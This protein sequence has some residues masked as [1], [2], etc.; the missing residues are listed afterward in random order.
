MQHLESTAGS[1]IVGD[2][3]EWLDRRLGALAVDLERLLQ[4]DRALAIAVD[5]LTKRVG[6]HSGDE[7]D[8]RQLVAEHLLL[9]WV[10]A[11]NVTE[12][13]YEEQL[14]ERV[15]EAVR[16]LC[17]RTRWSR[18][19]GRGIAADVDWDVVQG[20]ANQEDHQDHFG[21]LGPEPHYTPAVGDEP[22]GDLLAED[23]HAR[24]QEHLPAWFGVSPW[25]YI[26]SPAAALDAVNSRRDRLKKKRKTPDDF[27]R[28]LRRAARLAFPGQCPP[29]RRRRRA[30]PTPPTPQPEAAVPTVA[31]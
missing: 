16:Y 29:R 3:S 7:D 10:R 19:K 12:A 14:G 27:R 6:S 11:D 2:D 8:V 23:P 30:V 26:Q 31:V 21:R 25:D 28:A 24:L 22:A 20:A 1:T 15:A 18:W 17:S 5:N 4:Q 13:E 9:E